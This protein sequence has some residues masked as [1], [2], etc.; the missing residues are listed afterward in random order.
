MSQ[1]ELNEMNT[2]AG[3]ASSVTFN[4][5]T[6]IPET[7]G[8]VDVSLTEPTLNTGSFQQM[9]WDALPFLPDVPN[10]E[11]VMRDVYQKFSHV[12]TSQY[13]RKKEGTGGK[14]LSY[15]SWAKAWDIVLS[16]F[17]DAQNDILMFDGKPYWDMGA[18]GCVVVTAITIHGVRRFMW[19]PVMDM[20]NDPI[21]IDKY[22][23]T[24]VI[25][26][27]ERE[28]ETEALDTSN[29]NKSLMRCL[30]KNLAMFGLGIN[31]YN[32]DDLPDS[33]KE[34]RKREEDEQAELMSWVVRVADIAKQKFAG[35]KAEV[36]D[37]LIRYADGSTN[38]KDIKD[39][40]ACKAAIKE[41]NA[42][43]EGK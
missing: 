15:L 12:D 43:K 11:E 30:V 1:N 14:T 34:S 42:L 17:P 10:E 36:Q 2:T 35:H 37:I 22:K 19:L 3:P 27:V 16:Y 39:V 25:K 32:G 6:V 7:T 33:V 18:L 20:R 38:P 24:R 9:I 13:L 31:L 8:A 29:L 5:D 40:A 4:V 26:G 41:L 28:Y 23:F 21:H